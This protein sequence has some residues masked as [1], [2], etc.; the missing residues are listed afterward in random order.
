M[1]GIFNS[2]IFNNAVFNTGAAAIVYGGGGY[3]ERIKRY[4]EEKRLAELKLK[5][6]EQEQRLREKELSRI[7]A[8]REDDLADAE[9]Q[10]RLL[11]AMREIERLKAEHAKLMLAIEFF[12][13]DEEDITILL[14][15]SVI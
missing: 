5:Q 4:R 12:R 1:P 3:Y 2:S 8:L 10:R 7:E 13:R 11:V 15:S 14:L 9:L 6:N